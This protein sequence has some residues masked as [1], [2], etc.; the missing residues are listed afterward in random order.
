MAENETIGGFIK[1]LRKQQN[2]S[3]AELAGKIGIAQGYLA[4]LESGKKIGSPETLI[5]VGRALEINPAYKIFEVFDTEATTL[6]VQSVLPVPSNLAQEDRVFLES[7]AKLLSLRRTLEKSGF[8]PTDK[9]SDLI[10]AGI[11]SRGD[12]EFIVSEKKKSESE[13]EEEDITLDEAEAHSDKVSKEARK[14]GKQSG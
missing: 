5:R 11:I 9:V 14:R 8:G 3:Q 7:L 6:E 2:L 4:Q 10:G 13:M 12:V 1:R